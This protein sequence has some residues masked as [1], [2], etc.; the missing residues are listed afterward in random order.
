MR[1]YETLCN[2]KE[3]TADNLGFSPGNETESPTTEPLWWM[4]WDNVYERCK[5]KIAKVRATLEKP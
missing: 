4:L 3:T 2:A 5:G 1:L